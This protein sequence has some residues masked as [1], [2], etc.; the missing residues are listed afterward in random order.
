MVT[1]AS[2]LGFG[3]WGNS[4]STVV[5]EAGVWGGGDGGAVVRWSGDGV[6]LAT[7]GERGGA[8]QHGGSRGGGTGSREERGGV[9]RGE[10]WGYT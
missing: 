4:S 8:G 2:M 7:G 9:S 10:R 3:V 1:T 6:T 5:E